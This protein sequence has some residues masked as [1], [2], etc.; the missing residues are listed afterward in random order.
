MAFKQTFL[1]RNIGTK[2][3]HFTTKISSPFS[4]E[5]R[6]GLSRG[7]FAHA[8][9]LHVRAGPMR[10]VRGGPLREVR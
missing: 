10:H 8:V 6:D 9:M 5:P 7:R 2:P 4:V 3:V 1:V